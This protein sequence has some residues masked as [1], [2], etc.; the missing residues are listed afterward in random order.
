MVIDWDDNGQRLADAVAL[1]VARNHPD[2][3]VERAKSTPF[4]HGTMVTLTPPDPAAARLLLF[5]NFDWSFSLHSGR[6]VLHEDI[7]MDE[8]EGTRIDRVVAAIEEIASAGLER[9]WL[10]R[11]IGKRDKVGAW[12]QA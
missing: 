6:F 3:V 1:I 2:V 11:L 9:T 10:D 7:P 12:V 5:A 8:S 4:Y